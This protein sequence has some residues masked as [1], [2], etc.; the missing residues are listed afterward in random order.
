MK[1]LTFEEFQNR[2]NEVNKA[3]RIFKPLT[4]NMTDAF[5]L[6][7]EVLAEE[8]M[9]VMIPASSMANRPMT[10]FDDK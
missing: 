8:K 3:Y 4:N 7:Q 9:D 5:I 6:Y 10:P 2:V 1:K